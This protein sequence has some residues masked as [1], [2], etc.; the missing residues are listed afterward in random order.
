LLGF[1]FLISSGTAVFNPAWQA[2]VNEQ[3]PHD[4]LPAAVS[5]NAISF[6]SARI[7]GPAVGG[8]IVAATS[9]A[10]AFIIT[11]VGYIPMLTVLYGWPRVARMSALPPEGLGRAV[12]SGIRYVIHSPHI[13]VLLVR[14][15]L[16]AFAV[17]SIPALMPLVARLQLGGDARTFGAVLM[18]F[19][20]G[21]IVSSFIVPW[22]RRTFVHELAV[23]ACLAIYGVGTAVVAVS[24]LRVV[25]GAAL[26]ACGAGWMIVSV[27]FNVGVQLSSPRW[28][29]ARVLASFQATIT[30]GMGIGSWV[31]GVVVEGTTLQ[32]AL[33]VSA[34]AIFLS[35]ALGL[36][37]PM[38]H[39]EGSH[40]DMAASQPEPDIHLPIAGR[41][42][43]VVLEI[44]YRVPA[45]DARSFY[46]TMMDV[47]LS[48]QRNGA[49]GWSIARD[50]ANPDVW[51]ER[52]HYPTWHD[53]LRQ[54]DRT[55]VPDRE[56][57]TRAYAFHCGPKPVQVRRVLERPF[58]ATPEWDPDLMPD[59]VMPVSGAPT[60]GA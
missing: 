15:F 48:R 26:I 43:P 35:A 52:L 6:N 4:Q 45:A 16:M 39:V 25:T 59:K 19:G 34:G 33:L 1:C 53:Y 11:V 31:W 60:G 9:S 50:V 46:Y 40:R 12:I 58:G 41:S 37:L 38:P 55:T 44:E 22:V 32:T 13:T 20:V 23:R 57:E 10:V 49:Y 51:I 29:S 14:T 54:R 36:W 56:L 27:L 8:L 17:S 21:A 24:H 2:S 42:G 18:A 28:V 30:A 47:Q 7:L 5:L 3:V